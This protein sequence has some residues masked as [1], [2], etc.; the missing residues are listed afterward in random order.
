VDARKIAGPDEN[1]FGVICRYK[2]EQNF[3]FFTV[4]SD[5]YYAISK[6]INGEESFVG[7]DQMQFNDTA[8]QLGDGAN[9]LTAECVSDRLTLSVNG[10]VLADVKDADL[11]A[12]DVGLIAGTYEMMGVDIL[13]DNFVVTRP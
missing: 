9:H 2:D 3:Y 4:G 11:T 5:G 6:I 12:G 7:M 1:D 10:T 8:I 13:F